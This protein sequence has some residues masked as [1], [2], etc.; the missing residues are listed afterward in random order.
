MF[1]VKIISQQ[2]GNKYNVYKIYYKQIRHIN[3]LGTK[4]ESYE[5]MR[6]FIVQSLLS[7]DPR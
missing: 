6:D 7:I 5:V 1:T 2:Y 3:Y 4:C